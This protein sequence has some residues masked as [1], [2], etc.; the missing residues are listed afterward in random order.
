MFQ[1]WQMG[2]LEKYASPTG[3]LRPPLQC[4]LS[5]LAAPPTPFPLP[6]LD[7]GACLHIGTC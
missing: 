1:A 2:V 3:A 7:Y 4:L 5:A 6:S